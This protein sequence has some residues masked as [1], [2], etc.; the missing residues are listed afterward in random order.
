VL[1]D[2]TVVKLGS[3]YVKVSNTNSKTFP[4]K[5]LYQDVDVLKAFNGRTILT[6]GSETA[7]DEDWEAKWKATISAKLS[8]HLHR[9]LLLGILP[10]YDA[11]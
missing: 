4:A 9:G 5:Y 8:G 11:G 1:K 7:Q 10:P 6:A 3:F 2:Y